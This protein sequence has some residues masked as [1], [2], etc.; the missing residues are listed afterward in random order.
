MNFKSKV[1]QGYLHIVDSALLLWNNLQLLTYRVMPAL[2]QI[3]GFTILNL[4][5]LLFANVAYNFIITFFVV[6]CS[7]A[8]CYH[9]MQIMHRQNTS[10]RES[11]KKVYNKRRLVVTWAMI[12]A[13]AELA[14]AALIIYW[15][16]F[17][18]VNILWIFASILVIP[19]IM[20]NYGSPST[21]A[22]LAY[23]LTMR[24][25]VEI[26]TGLLILIAAN[27]LITEPV[28]LMSTL[29]PFIASYAIIA[30]TLLIGTLRTIFATVVYMRFYQEPIEEL[31]ALMRSDI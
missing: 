21:I 28:I 19:I 20:A 25:W 5:C 14:L 31:E 2:L 15:P 23:N 29:S 16:A 9:V 26:I 12:V 6:L 17:L 11:F 24:A 7:A 30:V 18:L 3:I 8:L 1:S 10:I 4:G 22:R 13:L 27:I